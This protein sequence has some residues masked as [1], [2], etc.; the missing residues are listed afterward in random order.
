M[1]KPCKSVLFL[2]IMNENY[3]KATIEDIDDILIALEDSREV[4]RVASFG[5]WQDGYPSRSDFVNDIEKGQSYVLLESN[6]VI[7]VCALTY[8]EEDY[9]HLYEGSWLTDLPYMVMHRVCLKK[10]YY[11]QGYGK[12]IFDIFINEGIKQGYKSLRIDTHED[13]KTMLH[14]ISL[15]GFI[16]C[17]KVILP[18]NKHRL[19]FEKYF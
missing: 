5:Q 1:Q 2:L 15:Y 17:G 13:N 3:R 11:H 19:V 16:Y 6:K 4:L 8:Y 14:L 12:K 10:E 7:G 9:H 18:P